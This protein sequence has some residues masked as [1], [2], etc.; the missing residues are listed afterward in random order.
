METDTP[1]HRDTPVWGCVTQTQGPATSCKQSKAERLRI[2]RSH[3]GRVQAAG[4][5]ASLNPQ[6]EQEPVDT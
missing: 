6:R 1:K 5:A 2:A 3:P 4:K